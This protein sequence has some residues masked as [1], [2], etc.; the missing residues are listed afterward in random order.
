MSPEPHLCY[1]MNSATEYPGG[2]LILVQLSAL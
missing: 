1:K 2:V